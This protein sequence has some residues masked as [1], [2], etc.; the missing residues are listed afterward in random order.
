MV[1]LHEV[2]TF[3]QLIKMNDRFDE[4]SL[5]N[6]GFVPDGKGGWMPANNPARSEAM[7]NLN[8]AIANRPKPGRPQLTLTDSEQNKLL[9]K[10][11]KSK[12]P[13]SR[14]QQ[15]CVAWFRSTYPQHHWLLF[16][17]PNGGF[18]NKVTAKYIQAEGALSGVWDLFLSIPMNGQHGLY[19]EMKIKPNKLTDN[20]AKFMYVVA[21]K[22]YATAVCY[23]E[24]EFKTAIIDYLK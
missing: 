9:K 19:I 2:L 5:R 3:F 8:T 10:F 11:K 22:G 1:M 12:F 20:Q 14:L 17:I 13:E 6:K 23:T 4:Q 15:A 18:R 24:E 21:F 7:E 16:A